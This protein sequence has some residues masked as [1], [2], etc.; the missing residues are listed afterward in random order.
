MMCRAAISAR[1]IK[2]SIKRTANYWNLFRNV[3]HHEVFISGGRVFYEMSPRN[4]Q[5]PLNNYA[6][7]SLLS[8]IHRFHCWLAGQFIPLVSVSMN[9]PEPVY[10]EEYRLLF[11]GTP[12][13]YGQPFCQLEF[14]T[15]YAALEIV[16]T[17]ETL[18]T[19]LAG[20]NLSLLY[21]PKHYRVIGDQV[22]QWLENNVRQGNYQATLTQ[23]A[24][25]F[26]MSPQVLPPTPASR[27][28]DVQ[29]N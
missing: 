16:Q 11:Y 5:K 13:K 25:H 22:R 8:S 6:A 3:Y 12:I 21:Q 17:G 2:R 15:R 18:D 10:S 27:A 28:N 4:G 23:A 29:G 1:T 24:A 7:E 26:Q 9:Y 19:Y 14:E 20:T